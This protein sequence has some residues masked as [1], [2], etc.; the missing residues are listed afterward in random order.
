MNKIKEIIKAIYLKT[1]GVYRLPCLLEREIKKGWSIL[2]AGCGR[3]SSLGGVAKGSYK[4]GL[5]IYEPYIIESKR[6]MMHND[7]VLGDV[8]KMPFNPCS[9]D[10]VVSIEVIEHLSK[11]QGLVMIREM[12]RVAKNKIILTAPNGL[13][14]TSAGPK[15]NPGEKHLSGWTALELKEMEF[16]VYGIGGLKALWILKNGQAMCVINIP[17][18]RSFL[19]DISEFFAYYFPSLAFQLFFVKTKK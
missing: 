2:D 17:I 14:D 18:I 12:E 13:L 8:R 16:K 10:C 19:I 11:D 3:S 6:K 4:I 15:D 9:Y 7:Y 1:I 5:D